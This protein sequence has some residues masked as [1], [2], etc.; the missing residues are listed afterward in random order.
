MVWRHRCP[1]L[2]CGVVRTRTLKTGLWEVWTEVA[3]RVRIIGEAQ[4]DVIR[5][6]GVA[7]VEV[8]RERIRTWK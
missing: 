8:L 4:A 3:E 1:R 2:R 6:R 7:E 5:S